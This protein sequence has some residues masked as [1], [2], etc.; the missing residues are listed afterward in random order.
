M[1]T[2]MSTNPI[3]ATYDTKTNTIS[4][5]RL[6]EN[7]YVVTED[8]LGVFGK[9]FVEQEKKR[10][11][12]HSICITNPINPNLMFCNTGDVVTMPNGSIGYIKSADLKSNKPATFI[13]N[14]DIE[15]TAK[16]E[17]NGEKVSKKIFDDFLKAGNK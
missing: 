8:Q 5:C 10:K 2:K 11:N 16:V 13:S 9:I 14:G 7:Q 17:T 12:N 1:S 6:K 3:I 15:A 4:L